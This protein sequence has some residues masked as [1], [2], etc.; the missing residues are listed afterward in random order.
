MGY[1]KAEL[2]SKALDIASFNAVFGEHVDELLANKIA[3]NGR[4]VKEDL[5]G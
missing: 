1:T 5:D 4:E 2:R 3:V